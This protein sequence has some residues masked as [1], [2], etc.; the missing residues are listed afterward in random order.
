MR[1]KSAELKASKRRA[2]ALLL[3][4]T[5]VFALTLAVPG[6][7]WI[8]GVK[9]VAEAAMVGALADWFAVAALFR[10]VPIPIVSR[11]TE[12]VPRNKERIADNLAQFVRERFLDPA[13][14]V[15]LIQ[16]HDPAARLAQWLVEPANTRVH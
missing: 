6:G 7:P 16:R 5:A 8:D 11:H 9:A 4:V 14:I 3:A 13:S 10:R 12:I 2:L 15:A 1:D